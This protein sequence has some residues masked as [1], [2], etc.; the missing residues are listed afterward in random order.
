M[1]VKEKV[2]LWITTSKTETGS[3]FIKYPEIYDWKR[4]A[5]EFPSVRFKKGNKDHS[6]M[7][8]FSDTEAWTDQEDWTIRYEQN[9]LVRLTEELKRA[10]NINVT[11]KILDIL[12]SEDIVEIPNTENL[13]NYEEVL[14]GVILVI[15][16]GQGGKILERGIGDEWSRDY[17]T[18][19]LEY[20]Q[21]EATESNI[22][23]VF[24]RLK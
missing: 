4:V 2:F 10:K 9:I 22:S 23:N 21:I 1:T 6:V 24:E 17:I 20:F 12:K 15:R 7:I 18:K 14:D 8:R 13:W 3:N 11:G 5:L 19:T 16:R